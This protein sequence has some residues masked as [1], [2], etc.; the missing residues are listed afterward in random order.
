MS[1]VDDNISN[2][3]ITCVIIRFLDNKLEVLL[4]QNNNSDEEDFW[5]LPRKFIEREETAMGAVQRL[6]HGNYSFEIGY[7]DQ[8]RT[9]DES[10]SNLSAGVTIGHFAFVRQQGSRTN[11]N[12]LGSGK[13]FKLDEMP[14][15]VA[16]HAEILNYSLKYLNILI[17]NEPIVFDLLPEKFTLLELMSL[18]EQIVR[19][20]I[21][22]SNFRRKILNMNILMEFD[23]K[24]QDVSHR[25]ARFYGFDSKKYKE[26]KANGFSLD[27]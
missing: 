16:K 7:L 23:E 21:D 4:Q 27:F 15:I 11:D 9:F 12:V 25:A 24:Q 20:E 5:V 2:I 18:Y 1:K 14:N 10:N 13:W 3:S 19:V 6:L 8:F 26:N 17:K 22:K